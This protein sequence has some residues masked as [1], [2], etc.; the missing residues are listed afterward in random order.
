M[1]AFPRVSVAIIAVHAAVF[2]V[3]L[4]RGA[5]D[6]PGALVGLGAL[7][8]AAVR[9]GE[10]WRLLSGTFLHGSFDHLIG[11][12]IALYILGIAAEHA[13]GR[14][15]FLALYVATALAGSLA[16]VA[17]HPV[18]VPAVGA[19]GA[20][21]GLMGACIF[22]VFRHSAR[23]YVRDKRIG[24][25]IAAWAVYSTIM[26]LLTPFVDNLAHVGGLL[27]GAALAWVLRPALLDRGAP[28]PRWAWA[29]YGASCLAL[30]ATAYF[31]IPRLVG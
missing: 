27:C 13:F 6:P 31:W 28:L 12:A 23:L 17:W 1:S 25:V 16:S 10:Y 22:V 8:R 14:P 18:G 24:I 2:A 7:E 21:F 19:S 11:N 20:I 30:A 29:S 5:L 26:G 15:Q 4:A 9:Q 3:E